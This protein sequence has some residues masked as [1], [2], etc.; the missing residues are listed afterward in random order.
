MF[1]FTFF[2]YLAY[3]INT[4]KKMQHSTNYRESV[5]NMTDTIGSVNCRKSRNHAKTR[6]RNTV[7]YLFVAPASRIVVV[8]H[9]LT[10]N[11]PLNRLR[12]MKRGNSN[13]LDPGTSPSQGMNLRAAR[14]RKPCLP[15]Q[16][17]RGGGSRECLSPI[18]I[19]RPAEQDRDI[20]HVDLRHASPSSRCF[21]TCHL[22]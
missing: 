18:G 2:R 4:R 9:V 12:F 3:I 8:T 11:H 7:H 16:I 15:Q 13:E 14:Q 21:S 6:N 1:P 19:I 17:F 20:A 10:V 22:H 5:D